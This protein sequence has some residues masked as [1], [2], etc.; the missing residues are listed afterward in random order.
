MIRMKREHEREKSEGEENV[1]RNEC[2]RRRVQEEKSAGVR[3][4]NRERASMRKKEC[5]R[6]RMQEEESAGGRK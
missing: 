6:K 1:G 5:R 4:Y 3:Q 2:R